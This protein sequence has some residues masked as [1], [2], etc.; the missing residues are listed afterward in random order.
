VDV[1]V[2]PNSSTPISTG[3]VIT[4]EQSGAGT[5]TV[6]PGPGVTV[7][8]YLGALNT[9]GQYSGIQLIK[10]DTDIWTAFGGV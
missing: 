5:V 9:A 1:T 6:Q 3:S 7:N 2:P 4:L 10:V 8:S